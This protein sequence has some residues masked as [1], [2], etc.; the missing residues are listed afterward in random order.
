MKKTAISLIFA[1][2]SFALAAQTDL[3][4]G[5]IVG[6][7]E[8]ISTPYFAATAGWTFPFGEMGN[9]YSSFMNINADLGWK[10]QKNWMWNV[11]FG[12]QFG[13]NNVKIKN[14]ILSGMLTS[15]ADP[16]VISQAGTD[17]GLIA[18]NRNLSLSVFCGKVVPL[19]FSNPNSGLL[20]SIGAGFLQHQIIYENTLENAPQIMGDYALGYDRQMFGPMLSS[21]VGYVHMSKKSFANFFVGLRFDNAWT[22][23]TRDYQFDLRGGDDNVYYDRMLT[24]KF[25]WMFPFFGRKA[26][27]I[28]F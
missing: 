23:M 28:Y 22:K 3:S 4:D 8:A 14:D 19:W 10:T 16:F 21:F 6:K 26:D 11:S 27:K 1:C 18:Y 7:D 20:F 12:F 2:I 17:A 5:I 9:R 13:S 15:T 24:I 25:G